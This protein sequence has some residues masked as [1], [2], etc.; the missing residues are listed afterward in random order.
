MKSEAPSWMW[1]RMK[2][3]LVG[4]CLWQKVLLLLWIGPWPPPFGKVP[5][6]DRFFFGAA[7]L[8]WLLRGAPG[9]FTWRH[10]Y[11][12][13]QHSVWTAD[14]AQAGLPAH[15][16]FIWLYNVTTW[17]DVTMWHDDMTW[18]YKVSHSPSSREDIHSQGSDSDVILLFGGMPG[19]LALKQRFLG[20]GV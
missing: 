7:S 6:L 20:T 3:I 13:W 17:C 15:D 12:Q 11:E 18:H 9:C 19:N 1:G 5:K 10:R 8:S 14:L 4:T 16:V 2:E